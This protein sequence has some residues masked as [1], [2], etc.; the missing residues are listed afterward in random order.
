MVSFPVK[1]LVSLITSHLFVFAFISF[2]LGDLPKKTLVQLMSEKVLLM[3][4]SKSFVESCLLS[5]LAILTLFLC[6]V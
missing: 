3:F 2:A 1:E 6:M 5:L 4:F